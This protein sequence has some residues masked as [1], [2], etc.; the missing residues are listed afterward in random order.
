[1]WQY[2]SS[3][4]CF[5]PSIEGQPLQQKAV[6]KG[7]NATG[8]VSVPLSRDNLCN[9][10]LK[11]KL[12]NQ[13][14]TSF[15]P[16]IEG[17]PLQLGYEVQD[18]VQAFQSLYRGTAFATWCLP[19]YFPWRWWVSIPLPR[20]SLC[21]SYEQGLNMTIKKKFQSLYRGT[22][23]ATL[24][25]TNILVRLLKTSF[26]PSIEG[27]PLQPEK[28]FTELLEQGTFQSL[29]RGSAFATGK[30]HPRDDGWI[31]SIPLSRDNLCNRGVAE[32]LIFNGYNRLFF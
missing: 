24:L 18:Q 6:A 30:P 8:D 32:A 17:Q 27:Q 13:R 14:K 5:N 10:G 19:H 16:S 9:I 28:S 25:E 26:N 20:D 21:N 4:A 2:Y 3:N 31:V 23:F 22:A 15:N 1:M 29:Y 12:I 7:I 11:K